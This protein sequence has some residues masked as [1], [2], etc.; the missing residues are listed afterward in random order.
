MV[1]SSRAPSV[2][3]GVAL[4][5]GYL[6]VFFTTW[7]INR[8][9]YTRIGEDTTTT[10]LWYALPTLFGCVFLVVA[11]SLLGWWRVTLFD[12]TRSGPGWVWVLPL[13]MTL[14]IV[15]N[16]FNV[17]A[18]SLSPALL[19]WSA[20]GAVGVGFGEEVA[21]RGTLLVGLRS[22]MNERKSW[23]VSTLLFAALH[24][25]NMFFGLPA[26]SMPI[27]VVLTF[28]MGSG[29][30]AVRRVSGTLLLPIALHG[31]WDS[32]LLLGVAAG[33]TPSL[34]QFTVYPVAIVGAVAVL[35]RAQSPV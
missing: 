1:G 16:F 31:L 33:V 20:L 7:A 5:L 30:Y 4:Y 34:L 10:K 15:N 8:V 3:L 35:R 6:A 2:R 17:P 28:I 22:A 25:P 13:L 18:D 26:A 11:I 23:F 14:I 27:Q 12:R 21:T 29:L 24:I 9:D 32:S 19:L